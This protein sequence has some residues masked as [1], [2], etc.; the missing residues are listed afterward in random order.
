MFF[1]RRSEQP[2]VPQYDA[3]HLTP[4]IRCSICTGERV[5]GFRNKENGRFTEVVLLRSEEDLSS[6]RE[7]YGVSGKIEEFY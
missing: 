7:R 2:T 6:F 1:H 5:A 4:A 3:E